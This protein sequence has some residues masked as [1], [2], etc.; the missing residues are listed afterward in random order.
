MA[1]NVNNMGSLSADS[2]QII[3]DSFMLKNIQ[4]LTT[5]NFPSLTQ[6]DTVDWEG[7]PQLGGL[8]FTTGLQQ[9]KSL[10]IQNTGLYT[11]EGVQLTEVD[12]FIVA[13]NNYLTDI[14]MPLGNVSTALSLEANGR[15]VNVN[16]PELI[17]AYNMTFRN[18]STVNIQS[19]ATLN[20]SLGFYSNY[21]HELSAPNLTTVGAGIAFVSNA[22]LTNISMPELKQVGGG[23]QVANNTDLRTI[24]GF[25][26]LVRVGG[27]VD[28]NGEFKT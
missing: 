16:F 24:D 8:S 18:C 9:V 12:Q 27:A 7:L 6:V 25:P 20:G 28:F 17:W 3:D 4:V 26:R 21:F 22:Q 10:S 11:L 15:N 14:T 1:K 2:L 19:L 23:L 5:M 13:N